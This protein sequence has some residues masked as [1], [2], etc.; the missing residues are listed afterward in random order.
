MSGTACCDEEATPPV[1]PTAP[2]DEQEEATMVA[3]EAELRR[4]VAD[5]EREEEV[6]PP[7]EAE[8]EALLS[9]CW[10]GDVG[11]TW[12]GNMLILHI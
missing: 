2:E 1:A 11:S 12:V 5:A 8:K 6:A 4:G 7:S 9:R 3:E 10:S